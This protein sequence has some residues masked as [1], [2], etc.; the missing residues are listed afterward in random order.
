MENLLTS[1]SRKEKMKVILYMAISIDG[2][3]AKKDGDSDW[4]SPV[5]TVNFEKMIKEKGCI[6]VGRRTFDQYQGNIYPVIG[7]T[8]IV[9]TTE[10]SLKSETNSVVYAKSPNEAVKLAQEKGHNEALLIG[11]GIT[12]GLFLK[13]GLVD[14]VF[15]SVH[16]LILGEGIKLFEKVESYI[17]LELINHKELKK[18]LIQLHYRIINKK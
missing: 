3:I 13:E 8:N 2:F 16:P 4:V 7:V 11:G 1:N 15:L 9:V 10:L 17:K 6:I 18:G 12:N 5:D 14:E